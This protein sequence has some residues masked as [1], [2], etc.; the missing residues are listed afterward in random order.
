MLGRR[1]GRSRYPKDLRD[2]GRPD[3]PLF[4][5]PLVHG[6]IDTGVVTVR[7]PESVEIEIYHVPSR[8]GESK[9][10]AVEK[11]DFDTPT[12]LALLNEIEQLRREREVLAEAFKHVFTC[13]DCECASCPEGTGLLYRAYRALSGAMD[14]LDGEKGGG[15]E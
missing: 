15:G 12:V 4:E 10:N 13:D 14:L 8:K 9:V 1:G 6:R 2:A 3:D 7:R 5:R 11:R